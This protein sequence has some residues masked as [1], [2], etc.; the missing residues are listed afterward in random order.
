MFSFGVN[1]PFN[2]D[3]FHV[4]FER[5]YFSFSFVIATLLLGVNHSGT[6]LM[7]VI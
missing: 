2:F 5:I 3:E 7:I 4:K 1:F 6:L